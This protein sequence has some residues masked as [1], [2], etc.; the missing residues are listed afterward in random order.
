MY[1]KTF[2][3]KVSFEIFFFTPTLIW[4]RKDKEIEVGFLCFRLT[5][6]YN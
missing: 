4:L 5:I 1:S 2:K 6:D 3:F